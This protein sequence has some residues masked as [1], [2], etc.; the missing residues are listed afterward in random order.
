MGHS[1]DF[2]WITQTNA[3]GWQHVL[4]DRTRGPGTSSVTKSLSTN[5]N[6]TEASGND[7]NHGF[8]SAFGTDGFT[9]DKG[10][11]SGGSYTNHNNWNYLAYSW[12]AGE[13]AVTYGPSGSGADNESS[14]YDILTTVR[15][16]TTT[17]VS[18]I[19][20]TGSGN[21]QDKIAHG[22][23]VIPDA[24]I[25]KS[26][27][28]AREWYLYT[29]TYD[30][31]VDFITINGNAGKSDSQSNAPTA[32]SI[33][34][35]GSTVNSTDDYAGYAF[36]SVEGFSKIDVYT[37]TQVMKNSYIWDSLHLGS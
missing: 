33:S 18:V 22:L 8:V 26:R 20:Y 28:G 13:S 5:S 23:G 4:Y 9:V 7:T 14:N 21:N 17:G 3:T 29:Q 16:N 35:F 12:D 15:A 27:T 6:R 31:T 24:W 1:P 25:L 36:K 10:T 37:G 11:Q 19:S 2:L 34:L 30:G 32:T